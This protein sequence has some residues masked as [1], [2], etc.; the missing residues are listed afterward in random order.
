[1]VK[2][3]WSGEGPNA[4]TGPGWQK[5]LEVLSA[6]RLDSLRRRLEKYFAWER[7]NEPE[8]LAWE[9]F[10]R[11]ARKLQDGESIDAPEAYL[12]GV[13]RM[14]SREARSRAAKTIG[15]MDDQ[16]V[17]IADAPADDEEWA[18]EALEDCLAALGQ[19]QRKLLLRYYEGDGSAR[20]R[21]REALARELG[22]SVNALRNRALR[23]RETMEVCFGL[24]KK[25]KQQ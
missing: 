9:C 3:S 7:V 13:A 10:L 12:F 25:Q 21:N 20:I 24:K 16:E 14:L 4:L 5:L 6:D 15:I 22:I 8:E 23:L 1:L 19:S 2:N 17:A 18:R 11:L